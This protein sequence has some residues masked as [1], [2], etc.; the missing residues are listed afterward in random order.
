MGVCVFGLPSIELSCIYSWLRGK[1]INFLHCRFR[2]S[3]RSCGG[4]DIS[5]QFSVTMGM[6]SLSG[7]AVEVI[8]HKITIM[9]K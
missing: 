9:F 8:A 3:H 1:C 5:F 4:V 6:I 2:N 7:F